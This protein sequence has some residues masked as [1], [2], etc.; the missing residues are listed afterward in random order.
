MIIVTAIEEF[1]LSA[2]L[3]NITFGGYHVPLNFFFMFL[4][5]KII[6]RIPITSAVLLSFF[7][8][9]AAFVFFS[10]G[11]VGGLVY[12]LGMPYMPVEPWSATPF[13][14]LTASIKLALIY[15]VLQAIFFYVI[16][17]RNIIDLPWVLLVTVVSNALS[18]WMV[19]ALLPK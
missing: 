11:V 10:V 6:V 9:V 16:S 8:N 15:I 12:A 14:F 7:S 17:K 19:Y 13:V 3:W 1:L 5:L 4:L 2:W 18:A